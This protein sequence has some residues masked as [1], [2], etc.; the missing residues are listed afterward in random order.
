MNHSGPVVGTSEPFA[1]EM[2]AE[3]LAAGEVI[4]IPTDTVYGIAA[5]LNHPSALAR[6]FEIKGRVV[7]KPIPVLISSATCP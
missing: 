6:L 2:A 4:A 7:D 5:S 1:I 3:R